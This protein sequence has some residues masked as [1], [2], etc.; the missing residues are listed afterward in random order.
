PAAWKSCR[1]RVSSASSTAL[2]SH[3]QRV[4]GRHSRVSL[5]QTR[6]SG[7]AAGASGVG[8]VAG[9]DVAAERSEA[10]V[11]T[12]RLNTQLPQRWRPVAPHVRAGRLLLRLGE[13]LLAEI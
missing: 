2:P 6:A 4:H 13:I 12:P 5:G 9:V 3:H 11:T 8:A 7:M 1:W 10:I